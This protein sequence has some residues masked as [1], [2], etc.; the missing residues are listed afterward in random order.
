MAVITETNFNKMPGPLVIS[1]LVKAAQN[2]LVVFPFKGVIP[3][4]TSLGAGGVETVAYETL[5]VDN[6]DGPAY[7]DE[8][9]TIDYDG[10]A[11]GT[12]IAPYYVKTSSGEI[13]EVAEDSGEA[14]AS[15]SLTV[16]K[17]GCFGTTP[18]ATGLAN[19]A[20]VYVL[21][22]LTLTSESTGLVEIVYLPFPDDPGV[23]LYG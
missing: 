2:D 23:R 6:A 12:R 21:Q 8:S 20:A 4:A 5:V 11:A 15:G 10:A 22:T 18:S 16:K 1:R 7:D 3:L 14:G 19:D 9:L 17:R 13:I